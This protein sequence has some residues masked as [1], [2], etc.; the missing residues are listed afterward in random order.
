LLQV[1]PSVL[2]PG[3]H[4]VQLL[5][6]LQ[7]LNLLLQLQLF[8]RDAVHISNI[9]VHLL[10]MERLLPVELL[11]HLPKKLSAILLATPV[12]AFASVGC[13]RAH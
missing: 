10:P 1:P 12:F 3:G 4:V 9:R 6:L 13:S 11:L 8:D 5:L 7:L 2:Q